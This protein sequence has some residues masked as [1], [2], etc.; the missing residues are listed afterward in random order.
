MKR[1]SPNLGGNIPSLYS[2]LS[3]PL[4]AETYNGDMHDDIE[5]RPVR[6]HGTIEVGA[7][8]TTSDATGD[9]RPTPAKE[10]STM[11]KKD[12]GTRDIKKGKERE[13]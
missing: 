4:D 5:I 8:R 13:R 7:P 6:G 2:G 11:A 1:A 9:P 3:R 12:E 10:V